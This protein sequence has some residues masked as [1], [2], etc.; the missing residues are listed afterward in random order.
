MHRPEKWGYVQF[1]R[2]KFGETKYV[3]D[4]AAPARNVLQEIYYA[5]RDF[6]A[7]NNRWAAT[8]E[9]LGLRGNLG[10]TKAPTI[11]LTKEGFEVSTDMGLANSKIQHWHIRQDA[12]VWAD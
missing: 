6:Q 5:Q 4:P 10:L 3:P 7:K 2:K 1:S 9:E 12:R 8:L 11:Q